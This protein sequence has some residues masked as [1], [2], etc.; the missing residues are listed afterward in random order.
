MEVPWVTLLVYNSLFASHWSRQS[1][2]T[3]SWLLAKS[4][5]QEFNDVL[6]LEL[7]QLF[8]V[9]NNTIPDLDHHFMST[10]QLDYSVLC[11]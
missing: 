6:L 3:L 4:S 2:I 11:K 10:L 7:G 9:E 5:I 8:N 1:D